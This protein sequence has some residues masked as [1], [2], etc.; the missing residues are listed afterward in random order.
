MESERIILRREIAGIIIADE[1]DQISIP[2][3]FIGHLRAHLLADVP[4]IEGA[5]RV[6]IAYDDPSNRHWV[7]QLD[8]K[9]HFEDGE[10]LMIRV[11]PGE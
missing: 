5:V 9:E 10:Y 11:P 6:E 1:R 2:E 4:G 3:R 7:L 8:D